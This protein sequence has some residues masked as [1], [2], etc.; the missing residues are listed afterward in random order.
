MYLVFRATDRRDLGRLR[1]LRQHAAG[2]SCIVIA[3]GPSANNAPAE[4]IRRLQSSGK[5]DVIAMNGFA[6]SA[7]SNEISPDWVVLSDRT[8]FVQ[9]GPGHLQLSL[10]RFPKAQIVVPC[11]TRALIEKARIDSTRIIYFQN[12]SLESWGAT[13]NPTRMRR[14]MPMTVMNSLALAH[15]FGYAR[16]GVIGLDASEHRQIKVDQRNRII[17]GWSH[18]T[19]AGPVEAKVI[20]LSD[21]IATEHGLWKSM[22]DYF[23]SLGTFHLQLEALFARRR[24]FFNLSDDS[25]LTCFPREG[26]SDFLIRA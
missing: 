5:L 10:E 11:D 7:L 21:G 23:Y 20:S 4:S 16:I 22:G 18:H 13:I 19:G 26:V 17:Q 24:I 3:G 6:G 25:D 12:R 14:Y 15:Y 9:G 2:K 8:S 1:R